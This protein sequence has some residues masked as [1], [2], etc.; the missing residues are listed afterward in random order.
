MFPKR[1]ATNFEKA[2]YFLSIHYLIF[3]DINISFEYVD[4]YAIF[5]PSAT[6]ILEWNTRS[7]KIK[8][9]FILN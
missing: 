2:L 3:E 9:G 7:T 8:K 1:L 6:T 5:P 4:F